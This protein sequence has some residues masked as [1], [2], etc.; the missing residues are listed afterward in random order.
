[1]LAQE[2]VRSDVK[3]SSSPSHPSPTLWVKMIQRDD[4]VGIE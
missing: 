3:G 1:M 2:D 4:S